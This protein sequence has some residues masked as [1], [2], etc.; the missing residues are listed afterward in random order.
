MAASGLRISW[1]STMVG[2]V[3]SPSKLQQ[4]PREIKT[5][6]QVT[7]YMPPFN[8]RY[9]PDVYIEWEYELNAIFSS[10][11]FSEREKLD[12]ATSTFTDLA[13]IWWTDYCRSYPDYMPTT[14]NDLKLVM[15]SRFVP[16]YYTRGMV[17]KLQNLNQGSDTVQEYFDAL[18]TTLLY[19]F[20]EETEEDLMDRFWNGLN[21]DIQ[22]LLMLEKYYSINRM[23]LLACKAEQKIKRRVHGTI[24]CKKAVDFSAS[25]SSV[26]FVSQD[27]DKPPPNVPITSESD[28]QGKNKGTDF[29][30]PHAIVYCNVDLHISCVGI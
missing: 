25:P 11:H 18:E 12:D 5:Y 24:K 21:H 17:R 26:I 10:Y 22:D 16:S 9:K 20:I 4:R 27:N 28:S 2:D 3:P 13:S 19:A 29:V 8:G 15:R 7:L 23:F 30:P 6:D 1:A 14:W